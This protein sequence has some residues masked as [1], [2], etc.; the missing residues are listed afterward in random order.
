MLD[1]QS[2]VPLYFQLKSML[3]DQIRTGELHPGEKILSEHELCQRYQISR[4]TARQAIQDLVRAG[5]L[6]RTQGRGT[7]V[8]DYHVQRPVEQLIGL[9]QD[10]KLQGIVLESV[11]L[12]FSAVVPP[13]DVAKTLLLSPNE[14]AIILKRQRFADKRV[15][16]VEI[17]YLPFNRFHQIL[18][19]DLEK[20]SLYQLLQSK[21]QT[22]PMR[23]INSIT[24]V[25]LEREMADWLQV[26]EGAPALFM[27]ENVFDQNGHIFEYC[28][29]Y[30]RGDRY[31]YHV[32]INKQKTLD[33]L[34]SRQIVNS[35]PHDRR[36]FA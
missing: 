28:N 6:V 20:H 9:T 10:M 34:M 26:E 16:G 35:E 29:V 2:P 27:T 5:K 24:A 33:K 36:G 7:F 32:E 17:V 18:E 23:S 8:A 11:V 22:I 21:F 30:Y 19:Y 15:F 13:L 31:N 3:E 1:L 4:T 25:K 14:A 12:Q